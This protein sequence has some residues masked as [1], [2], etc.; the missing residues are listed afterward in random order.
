M[1][2]RGWK[3]ERGSFVLREVEGFFSLNLEGI[4][5]VAGYVLE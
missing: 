1:E 3:C 2:S 4:R 5:K